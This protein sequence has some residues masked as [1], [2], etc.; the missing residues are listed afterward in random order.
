M[1]LWEI[2][3]GDRRAEGHPGGDRVGHRGEEPV[4]EEPGNILFAGEKHLLQ[5]PADLTPPFLN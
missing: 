3:A 4:R 1:K 5:L 2:I